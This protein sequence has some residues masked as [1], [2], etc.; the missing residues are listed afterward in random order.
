[1]TPHDIC[2]SEKKKNGGKVKKRV[3]SWGSRATGAPRRK[4]EKTLNQGWQTPAG[5]CGAWPEGQ[6]SRES[7]SPKVG[8]GKKNSIEKKAMVAG[9]AQGEWYSKSSRIGK[10][11]H[12]RS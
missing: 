10:S 11:K 12:C 2:S 7:L 8:R 6:E 3:S 4:K 1:M 9:F 5:E